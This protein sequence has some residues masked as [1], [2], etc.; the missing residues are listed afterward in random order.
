MDPY[1]ALKL[2][3]G[4]LLLAPLTGLIGW[5]LLLLTPWH[6]VFAVFALVL[7]EVHLGFFVYCLYSLPPQR[8]LTLIASVVLTLTLGVFLFQG[9]EEAVYVLV[10]GLCLCALSALPKTIALGITIFLLNIFA[11]IIAPALDLPPF[12]YRGGTNSYLEGPATVLS[13][14]YVFL[15]WCGLGIALLPALD[16]RAWIWKGTTKEAGA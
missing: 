2:G 7:Y 15:A 6:F 5:G 16:W 11:L 10:P 1:R 4:L 13:L 8:R 9:M 3:F 14:T 12:I